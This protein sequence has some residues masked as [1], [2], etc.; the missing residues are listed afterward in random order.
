MT[1]REFAV[2]CLMAWLAGI[3]IGIGG[4]A[5]L[6]ASSRIDGGLGKLVGGFLFALGM[7]AIIA[8]DMRLFTGMVASLPKMG[9]KNTWRLPVCFIFNSLGVAFIAMLVHFSPLEAEVAP[10][11][12]NLISAKLNM[13]GWAANALGSG[14][15]CGILITASIWSAHYAPEKRLSVTMGVILPIVVF[16]FCGFDHS[17]A[18]MLYFYYLGEVS[19]RVV[20]YVLLSMVG[21]AIGGVILPFIAMLRGADKDKTA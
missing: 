21:N 1:R 4:T 15:I 7:Y 17:V 6:L 5:S 12:A 8:Y 19:W 18:N 20:G 2:F 16:A 10:A 9:I 14:I 13:D 3:M 11:A